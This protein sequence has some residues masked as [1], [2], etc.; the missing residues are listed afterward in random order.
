MSSKN[1]KEASKTKSQTLSCQDE[2]LNVLNSY[3]SLILSENGPQEIPAD[4]MF[5]DELNCYLR[6]QIRYYAHENAMVKRNLI[7]LESEY[8]TS[9]RKI[10]ELEQKLS[11]YENVLNNGSFV[12]SNQVAATKIVEL[13]K[14]IREKT[15]EVESLKTKCSRL[16]KKLIDLN[17]SKEK[18]IVVKP[19]IARPPSDES[20][21]EIKKLNDKLNQVNG[22]LSEARNMNLQLKN[23][24]K[25]ANKWLQQEIGESF[26]SLQAL[27]YTNTNWRGR[28]Q[29]II[30]LQQKNNDLKEKLRAS[31]NKLNVCSDNII[32]VKDSK[33]SVLSKEND[34][35]KSQCDDLKKKY[36]CAKA[37]CRILDTDLGL[38]KSKFNMLKD[39]SEKDQRI[40]DTLS[41]QLSNK[42]EKPEKCQ[43]DKQIKKLQTEKN[44]LLKEIEEFKTVIAELK[45]DIGNKSKQIDLLNKKVSSCKDIDQNITKKQPEVQKL[46]GYIEVQ[47]K[48][49]SSERDNHVKT[50]L[51]LKTEKQKSAKAEVLA[52]MADVGSNRSGS[53]SSS[54]PLRSTETTLR[55]QLELAEENLKAIQTRLDIE[56]FERKSD[57]QEFASIL[58]SYQQKTSL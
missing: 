44:F 8:E 28:S 57:L 5:P 42:E 53:Y 51:L 41:A 35:L 6:E 45:Q 40:I 13:S 36:D 33:I 49:L 3:G 58:Q 14:K 21:D 11:N 25:M 38:L 50:Q 37:R 34:D 48:R 47:N 55:D 43:K 17:S 32:S 4:I 52:A 15:S 1:L 24:L 2:T 12:S 46:L 26:E 31:Q 19:Q 39:Q 29:I 20:E 56:Q 22:K 23:D 27:C 9:N 7:D 54:L 18:E 16:E 30:D 10:S